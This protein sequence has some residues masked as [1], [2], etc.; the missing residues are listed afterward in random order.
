MRHL[1]HEG[2]RA[3]THAQQVEAAQL[4]LY[5]EARGGSIALVS[6]DLGVHRDTLRKHIIE[7]GLLEW[8]NAAYPPNTGA[9]HVPG[10]GSAPAEWT[11]KRVERLRK[12]IVREGGVIVRAAARLGM[13]ESTLTYQ[14]GTSGLGPWLA[15]TYPVRADKSRGSAAAVDSGSSPLDDTP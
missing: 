13:P 5:L 7:L 4:R 1:T 6:T 11:A 9:R 15:A 10:K 3:A 14:V 2:K 8:L 12:A